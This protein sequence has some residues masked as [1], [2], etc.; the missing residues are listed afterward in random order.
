M[1]NEE[2]ERK[3]DEAFNSVKLQPQAAQSRL[4]EPLGVKMITPIVCQL[5]EMDWEHG[6][7][8][9]CTLTRKQLDGCIGLHRQIELLTDMVAKLQSQLDSALDDHCDSH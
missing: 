1:E 2:T 9:D 7:C 3:K 8:G 5:C 4:I 6:A